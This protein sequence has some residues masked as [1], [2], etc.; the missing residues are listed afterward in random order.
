MDGVVTLQIPT[1]LYRKF[2]DYA[3]GLGFTCRSAARMVIDDCVK[4][5]RIREMMSRGFVSPP[6][7]KVVEVKP[8][9]PSKPTKDEIPD[10]S[11]EELEAFLGI[12]LPDTP[13]GEN[14][15]QGNTYEAY[16]ADEPEQDLNDIL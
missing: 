9:K 16:T 13:T 14:G 1:E 6:E 4:S 5:D 8:E 12:E 11:E 7:P 15:M 2:S 3:R 10:V